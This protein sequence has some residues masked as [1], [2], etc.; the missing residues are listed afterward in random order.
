MLTKEIRAE[1]KKLGMD[2]GIPLRVEIGPRDLESGTVMVAR[3][4]KATR[5]RLKCLSRNLKKKFL[6]LEEIQNNISA[7]KEF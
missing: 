6:Y 1:E 2:K 4:D 5:I 3:R 7:S